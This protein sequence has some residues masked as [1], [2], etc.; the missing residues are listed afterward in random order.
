MTDLSQPDRLDDLVNHIQF[1]LAAAVSDYSAPWRTPMLATIADGGS[2][3]TLRTVV[4]RTVDSIA[5]CVRIYTD[6]RSDKI[7]QIADCSAVELGFWDPS[8]SEQLR[9]AGRAQILTNADAVDTAWAGLRPEARLIY[10][11]ANVSGAPLDAATPILP[12]AGGRDVFT[13]IEIRW[14]RW[15]WLWLDQHS[16]HRARIHWST[17]GERRAEWIVP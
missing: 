17:D 15:D 2:T 6:R 3:P 13:V 8:A 9:V 1:R 5:G 16:H 7:G 14:E 12:D 4:I 11:S 10:R